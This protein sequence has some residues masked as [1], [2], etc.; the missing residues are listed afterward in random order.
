M[1]MQG[2]RGD[3]CCLRQTLEEY[4]FSNGHLPFR[5]PVVLSQHF[6]LFPRKLI[7]N[8]KRDAGRA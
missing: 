2:V 8:K 4:M 1:G 6:L 7:T 5:D 3:L